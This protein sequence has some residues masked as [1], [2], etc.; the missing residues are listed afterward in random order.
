MLPLVVV[1]GDVASGQIA[2][3]RFRHGP[4]QAAIADNDIRDPGAGDMRFDT[5]A[6]C[7]YFR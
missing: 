3:D 5:A 6:A 7:L 1:K 4:A 2:V